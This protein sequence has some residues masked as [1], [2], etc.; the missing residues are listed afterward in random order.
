MVDR[1][2]LMDHHQ[3]VPRA[4]LA[5]VIV[6][7]SGHQPGVSEVH[8]FLNSTYNSHVPVFKKYCKCLGFFYILHFQIFNVNLLTFI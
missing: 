8:A 6:I 7:L 2:G 1:R 3:G 4:T 5:A